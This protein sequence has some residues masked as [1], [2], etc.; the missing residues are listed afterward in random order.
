MLSTELGKGILLKAIKIDRW[1]DLTPFAT[2]QNGIG[3]RLRIKLYGYSNSLSLNWM[4]GFTLNSTFVVARSLW[5]LT[6][7]SVQKISNKVKA[8]SLST[9][10]VINHGEPSRMIKFQCMAGWLFFRK[11]SS[12]SGS[13]RCQ[14]RLSDLWKE[15]EQPYA[16]HQWGILIRR[17]KNCSSKSDYNVN[18]LRSRTPTRMRTHARTH[19]H[20]H[21]HIFKSA[22]FRRL[23]RSGPLGG[24]L[25]TRVLLTGKSTPSTNSHN[26]TLANA[27]VFHSVC[28]V[29]LSS[30][31][32]EVFTFSYCARL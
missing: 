4:F 31:P 9:A 17:M 25:H 7:A 28:E 26:C 6:S 13:R 15:F 5:G 16:I 10:L 14:D 21:A 8:L 30:D 32:P 1:L 11:V 3:C 20:T 22:A 23:F 12:S 19:T 2:E 18:K 27:A 29:W 24:K